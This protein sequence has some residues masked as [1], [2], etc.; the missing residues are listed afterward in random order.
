ME[1]PTTGP[2]RVG[3]GQWA[4]G[5]GSFFQCRAGMPGV[6]GC[7]LVEFG[8]GFGCIAAACGCD[9]RSLA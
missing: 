1:W 7:D 4:V 3:S 8:C 9:Q 2:G 6:G 5:S